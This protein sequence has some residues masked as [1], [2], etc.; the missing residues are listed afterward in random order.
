MEINSKKIKELRIEKGFSQ[1]ELAEKTG[2]SLRTVQRI[3]NGATFPRGDSLKR[4]ASALNIEA[5][6]FITPAKE[7]DENIITI[8]NLSQLG[9]I[10]FPPLGIIVPLYLWIKKRNLVDNVDYVG[11]SILNFQISWNIIIFVLSVFLFVSL[12][13]TH[14]GEP[15]TFS[16]LLSL[17]L[18]ILL[19]I[20]NFL[21][22]LINTVSC[23]KNG[24]VRYFPSVKFFN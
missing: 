12:A 20:Y 18:I 11:K 1:E 19:Y 14:S 3:E 2:L 5:E 4:I 10:L 23:K 7:K 13:T 9:F 6:Q 21:M 15:L 8:L 24:K 22:I 16:K 17:P